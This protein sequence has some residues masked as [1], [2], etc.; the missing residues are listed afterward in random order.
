MWRISTYCEEESVPMPLD[1]GYCVL[2]YETRAKMMRMNLTGRAV[3]VYVL[4]PV[5]T[6]AVSCVALTTKMRYTS[7]TT[8]VI[9]RKCCLDAVAKFTSLQTINEIEQ[10]LPYASKKKKKRTRNNTPWLSIQNRA[11]FLH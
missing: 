9:D 7:Q 11:I 2:C 6:I 1:Q 8:P 4:W 5:V 3:P 10:F